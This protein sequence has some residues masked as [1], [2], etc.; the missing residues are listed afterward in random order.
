M[1]AVLP[2]FD[3]RPELPSLSPFAA[4]IVLAA[5]TPSVVFSSGSHCK[6]V[7]LCLRV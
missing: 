4:T 1:P 6:E 5:T 3:S 7:G 2:G